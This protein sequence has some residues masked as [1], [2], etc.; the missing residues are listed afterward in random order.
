MFSFLNL[1][2]VHECNSQLMWIMYNFII[3]LFFFF[4]FFYKH[5]LQLHAARRPKLQHCAVA[6]P[7]FLFCFKFWICMLSMLANKWVV[8]ML[9]INQSIDE[10]DASLYTVIELEILT[11]IRICWTIFHCYFVY[12][13]AGSCK[14]Y[15]QTSGR[16]NKGKL[17]VKLSFPLC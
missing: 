2:V 13:V 16:K 3:I 6:E 15:K 11:F 9:S 12:V 10:I 4:F 1:P 17:P 8:F 7:K 5:N 14:T